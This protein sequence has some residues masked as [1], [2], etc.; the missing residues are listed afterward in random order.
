MW[1]RIVSVLRR[2]RPGECGPSAGVFP[3]SPLERRP[4]KHQ[5]IEQPECLR[6]YLAALGAASK[7]LR[8]PRATNRW[9]RTG[10]RLRAICLGRRGL[11]ANGNGSTIQARLYRGAHAAW[12]RL[13]SILPAPPESW[14]EQEAWRRFDEKWSV[15]LRARAD[16]DR[17]SL[18]TSSGATCGADNRTQQ[19]R[20]QLEI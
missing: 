5:S 3:R 20:A 11:G 6:A 4:A 14:E 16:L 9:H 7:A 10:V 2:S 17:Y 1:K 15:L 12:L 19:H 18:S 13:T 8:P